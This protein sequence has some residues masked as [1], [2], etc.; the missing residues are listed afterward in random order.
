MTADARA[1]SEP[2]T[3]RAPGFGGSGRLSGADPH[4]SG[5]PRGGRTARLACAARSGGA[6]CAR[7]EPVRPTRLAREGLAAAS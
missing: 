4:A 1:A 5:L 6:R 7:H 2:R 3:G